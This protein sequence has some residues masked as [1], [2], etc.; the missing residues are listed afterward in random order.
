MYRNLV[1]L[2][3]SFLGVESEIHLQNKVTKK[4]M[5]QLNRLGI[6][7]FKQFESNQSE[8]HINENKLLKRNS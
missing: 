1:N 6:L 3:I 5:L 4:I 2:Y 7:Y 8:K